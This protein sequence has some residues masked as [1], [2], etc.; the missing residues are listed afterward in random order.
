MSTCVSY[1]TW[2]EFGKNTTKR[3]TWKVGD[4]LTD[5]SR[6]LNALTILHEVTYKMVFGISKVRMYLT[7]HCYGR[8]FVSK[9]WHDIYAVFCHVYLQ[10]FLL[11]DIRAFFATYNCVFSCFVGFLFPNRWPFSYNA[12]KK[13]HIYALQT[14]MWYMGFTESRRIRGTELY[15]QQKIPSCTMQLKGNFSLNQTWP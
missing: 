1:L 3:Q 5:I 4:K 15:R 12:H 8:P 7:P 14:S 10:S 13:A 2:I 11:Y 6:K 9:L